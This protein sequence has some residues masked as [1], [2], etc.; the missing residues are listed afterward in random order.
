MSGAERTSWSA[1][2]RAVFPLSSAADR[3]RLALS[4]WGRKSSSEFPFSETEI[5]LDLPHR[6]IIDRSGISNHSKF[7]C[8]S[9][10]AIVFHSEKFRKKLSLFANHWFSFHRSEIVTHLTDQTRLAVEKGK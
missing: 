2:D 4:A 3:R 9:R 5:E 7:A 10:F 6:A 8:L 1:T